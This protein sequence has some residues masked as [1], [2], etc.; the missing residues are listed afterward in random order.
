MERCDKLEINENLFS[1]NFNFYKYPL[2]NTPSHILK[3][4]TRSLNVASEI[5]LESDIERST[6]K[7]GSIE[8][9]LAV[10]HSREWRLEREI[11]E[12]YHPVWSCFEAYGFPPPYRSFTRKRDGAPL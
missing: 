4:I 2:I 1:S 11:V 3:N 10:R 7:S 12:G 5:F 9:I 6:S 8:E